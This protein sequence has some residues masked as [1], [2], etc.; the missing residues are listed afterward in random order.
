MDPVPA[1]PRQA[2]DR[3]IL[4]GVALALP[5]SGPRAA[6]FPGARSA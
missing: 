6:C 2:G 1:L 4:V 5:A 3:R